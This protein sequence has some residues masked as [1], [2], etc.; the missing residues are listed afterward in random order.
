M[1]QKVYALLVGIDDYPNP[2]LQ[3]RGCVND[4]ER[5]ERYLH[6]RVSSAQHPV[7]VVKLLNS[8]ATRPAIIETFRTHLGQ[9]SSQDIVLF[10]Y[11]GHGAQES[12]PAEF[13]HMEPDR[14]N[15]TLL[16][17]DSQLDDC[18]HLADKELAKLISDIAKNGSHIVAILDCC[19]SGSGTRGEDQLAIERY[20]PKDSRQRLLD[21]YVFSLEELEALQLPNDHLEGAST[22]RVL[23]HGRHILIAACRDG[24][25]AKEIYVDGNY[26]GALSYSLL[27]ILEQTN[28]YLSYKDIF[29]QVKNQVLNYRLDQT[30]QLEA[31]DMANINEPFLGGTV[32]KISQYFTVSYDRQDG[33]ILDAGAVHGISVPFSGQT[34]KLALFPFSTPNEKLN[35]LD[36]SIGSASVLAVLPQISK[37]EVEG[38]T[39]K[40][41]IYKATVTNIPVPVLGVEMIGDSEGLD[42]IQTAVATIGVGGTPSLYIHE[43]EQAEYCLIAKENQY[44]IL[45]SSDSRMIVDS[46]E[47]YSI[48]NARMAV[49]RLEHIA[50]WHVIARLQ[51][52]VSRIPTDAIEITIY[53]DGT[54]F[55][56]E[57]AILEY[58]H[59][60]GEWREP[61]FHIRLRNRHDKPLYCTLYSLSESFAISGGYFPA[62]GEWLEPNQEILTSTRYT[63]VPQSLWEAGITERQDILKLMICTAEFDPTLL[64]QRELDEPRVLGHR[65]TPM[66]NNTLS[67]LMNQI[68]MREV[69]DYPEAEFYDDWA[70]AEVSLTVRR[71][72]PSVA[73]SN[74]SGKLYLGAG[75][76]IEAHADLKADASLGTKPHLQSI[77]NAPILPAI[78]R[79]D[80][81]LVKPFQ[82]TRA[83]G[84]DPGLSFINLNN[85]QNYQSV[86]R[87]HT[88]CVTIESMLES[89]ETILPVSFD[90]K[91]YLPL[92]HV[93]KRDDQFVE[94]GIE[95]LPEPMSESSR[96]LHRSVWIL[97]QKLTSAPWG[98][99]YDYPRLGVAD[100]NDQNGFHIITENEVV[101][102]RIAEANEVVLCVHGFLGNTNQMA[103]TILGLKPDT[104]VLTFDYENIHTPLE[105]TARQLKD[106]M[107]DVGLAPGHN[108]CVRIV[109]FSMGGLIARWFIEREGGDQMVQQLILV[110]TPNT[111]SPW[112]AIHD[113][114][115]MALGIALNGMAATEWPVQVLS[116]R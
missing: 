24:E 69:V 16:C 40:T 18:W 33:W 66:I 1:E 106:R 8:E 99:D 3:L 32:K 25:T 100:V 86:T 60:N 80:P 39:D 90:G 114:G 20:G 93:T 110:G 111:G 73:L 47:G 113:W 9:A 43:A 6:G 76:S 78:L 115:T 42:Q 15:E 38:V 71:P 35:Q 64:E 88:L 22:R 19:H 52:K 27:G 67:Q 108:K 21:S 11:S 77:L 31:I 84:A 112:P 68:Q 12:A 96:S 116:T 62:G 63:I 103:Q 14:L 44:S 98:I 87:D 97:F 28:E 101:Q 105:Q 53:A 23:S 72:Q 54:S 81:D 102:Q 94:I 5:V 61:K 48:E 95:R 45:R 30:P 89:T 85:V 49:T 13:W 29:K 65:A 36:E 10:Y 107:I 91:F 75:I 17:W 57:G 74:S 83:K 59:D 58:Q 51:N 104:C 92:G 2:H 70:T 26:C 50:R 56:D 109:A 46:I 55:I 79:M 7:D 4:V 37:L 34:T 41:L 82:F